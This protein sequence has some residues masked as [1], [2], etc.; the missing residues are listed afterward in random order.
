MSMSDPKER[1][2]V[3]LPHPSRRPTRTELDERI[4]FPPGTTMEDLARALGRQVRIEH[5]DDDVERAPEGR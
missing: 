1:P 5:E 3:V 2:T 4:A